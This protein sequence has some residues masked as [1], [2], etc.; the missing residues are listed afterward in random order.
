ME[1]NNVIGWLHWFWKSFVRSRRFR[2][3]IQALSRTFRHGFKDFQGPCLFS[4]TFQAL[5]IWKKT[6]GLSGTHKSP[7]LGCWD[8][9]V[10]VQAQ[11][12]CIG[13]ELQRCM[14]VC[15]YTGYRLLTIVANKWGVGT[16]VDH[17]GRAQRQ[18]NST[19]VVLLALYNVVVM[20]NTKPS[21]YDV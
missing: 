14:E 20:G 16:D 5:K 18:K 9:R 2:N 4:R 1:R 12:V 6:Q 11:L 17:D 3:Q 7:V 13:D 19:F 10:H 15:R 8:W 21:S